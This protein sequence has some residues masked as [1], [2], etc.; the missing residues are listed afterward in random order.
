MKGKHWSSEAIEHMKEGHKNRK[1][2]DQ[3][4]KDA[5][6]SSLKGQSKSEAHRQS[7]RE[8]AK[9]RWQNARET[10]DSTS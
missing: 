3:A 4:T 8:A 1:P 5:I 9:R 7:L 10:S 2:M 6:R